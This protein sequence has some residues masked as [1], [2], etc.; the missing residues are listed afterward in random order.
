[1]YSLIDVFNGTQ[2][3]VLVDIELI[4]NEIREEKIEVF[5]KSLL[6]I[7]LFENNL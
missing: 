6:Y 5:L 2:D 4:L 1:M 3:Q 7:L